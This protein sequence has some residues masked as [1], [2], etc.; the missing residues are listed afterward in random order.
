VAPGALVI[1]V[2]DARQADWLNMERPL[3]AN[4]S[5][6]VVLFSDT[7]T[8]G[9]LARRAPDFFPWISHRLECPPAPRSRPCRGFAPPSARAPKA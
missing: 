7:A 1:V 5:L 3:L 2:P 9:D 8:S 6:R 4:R